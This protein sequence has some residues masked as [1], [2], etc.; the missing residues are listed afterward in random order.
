MSFASEAGTLHLLTG[1]RQLSVPAE[2]LL[3]V[4]QGDS[5]ILL[6]D[7]VWLALATIANRDPWQGLSSA[8]G[9]MVL[10]ADLTV[11]GLADRDLH[12]SVTRIDD[13]A[14]VAAS[15]RHPRCL[16]WAAN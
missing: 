1:H 3:T 2:L 8:I 15:E 12:P 6:Q 11:R 10:A 4:A 7:A 5:V 9:I 16:T 13:D 14:W